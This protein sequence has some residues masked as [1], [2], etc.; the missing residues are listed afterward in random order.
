MLRP[1]WP[2]RVGRH[3]SGRSAA[4]MAS[5]EATVSGSRYTASAISG[6][7]MIVAG[8][9]LT[10]MTR[11]PSSRRGATRLDTGVIEFSGLAN[12]DRA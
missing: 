5:I 6:S 8:F 7:V 12:D 10:R 2:P 4:M 3:A 9:E 11:W 1:V